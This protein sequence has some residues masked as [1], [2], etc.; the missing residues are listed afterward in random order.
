MLI[1]SDLIEVV[2]EAY[3]HWWLQIIVDGLF[4]FCVCLKQSPV[5]HLHFVVK[6]HFWD[7]TFR[8]LLYYFSFS[9]RC[10]RCS[11]S[12]CLSAE[13][14][15]PKQERSTKPAESSG[16]G[17][18]RHSRWGKARE[19]GGSTW[20]GRWGGQRKE[21]CQVIC[22]LFAICFP[23]TSVSKLMRKVDDMLTWYVDYDQK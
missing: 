7:F 15:I 23:Q 16:H 2:K 8:L 10:S 1:D 12:V 13:K 17:S 4:C 22:L 5:W 14:D 9:M 18:I 20:W 11:V 21:D 6:G 3:C 19:R